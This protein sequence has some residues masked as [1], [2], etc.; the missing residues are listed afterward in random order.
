MRL[1]S[2]SALIL[3]SALL[4]QCGQPAPPTKAT[5]LLPMDAPLYVRIND[6][7]QFGE[8]S[9]T[10]SISYLSAIPA[11]TLEQWNAGRWTGALLASGASSLDWVWTTEHDLT[12][13]VG[14]PTTLGN[15]EVFTLDSMYAYNDGPSWVISASEG[16]LQDIINQRTAG[17]SLMG[18]GGFKTLWDNASKSDDA[19]VFIQHKE[20]ARLGSHYFQ[21][22]WSWLE[23]YA[24]WSA[25][26][27]DWKKNKTIAT[28]VALCADSTNTYLSTF[29]ERPTGTDVSPIIAASSKYA[30]GINTGDPV[31]WLRAFNPYR[32]KKQRLKQAQKTL[33]DAGISPMT[34][35]NSFEGSFVRVGYGDGVVVAAKLEGEEMSVQDALTA[36]STQSSVYQGHAR[37]TLTESNRFLFSAAFGW[38]Y[39]DMGSASWMLWDQWLLV[40]TSGQLLE[41]YS[42]ELDM[43]KNWHALESLEALG[44][45]MDRNEHF[46]AAFNFNSLEEGPFFE[47]LPSALDRAFLAG[48]LEVNNGIAYGNATV[49]Q[50]GE[51]VAVSAY[52]WSHA[53]PQQAISGPFLIKNHRSGMTN[54]LVQDE[55]NQCFL[56][57]ENGEELWNVSLDGPI[58]GNVQ[59]LDMFKNAKFQMVFAT[60]DQ[61]HCLDILGREVEGFP[62]SLPEATTLGASVLDYDKN[63]NYRI[64][65]PAGSK[66]YNYSVEGQRID[67]WKID[68][69]SGTIT[70]SPQLYQ[71]GGKDYVI[72]S[73]LDRAH[74]LNRRGEERIKTSA[75]TAAKHP[76]VV[77]GGNPPSIM[78]VGEEG[79]I[80]EQRFDGT[81]DI[82]EH[83]LN[84]LQGMEAKSYGTLYWSEDKLSV[85]RETSTH[86]ITFPASIDRLEAYPGGTGI[87]Y[88]TEGTVHVTQLKEAAA[89]ITAFEGSEAEAGR[90][91]PAG[92][93]VLVLVQGNAVI[94][95]QL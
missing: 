65:V 16:L 70:Q 80:Q 91:T 76:W 42:S 63:R 26:D 46:T 38:V 61:L 59:Q 4:V 85:R 18:D 69:A 52:L 77:T 82:L 73:T 49:Q 13:F 9:D 56:L 14:A 20:V 51:E 75:L 95:Y 10:L 1:A 6:M 17:Y 86:T 31:E 28:A 22:D 92:A 71:R 43:N 88:D 27:L 94:C 19:N 55:S 2:L 87:I 78:R 35:A 41:V 83:D 11:H 8:T 72:I 79:E 37:G 54:I 39:S 84:N 58:Q 23:H 74:V 3:A 57:D 25:I 93:P 24:Q 50:R 44:D 12:P 47:T 5:S 34:F 40:G 53:L 60:N 15:Y 62:V 21:Q 36:L 81:T 48:H 90:L 32:G 30:V 66:L 89:P 64:L 68:A 7:H 29:T 67:G 45:A 33:E